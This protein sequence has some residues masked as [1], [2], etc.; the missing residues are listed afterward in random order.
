MTK[1]FEQTHSF[2]E[3][4]HG[5]ALAAGQDDAVELG[6]I[7][8][9]PHQTCP[10]AASFESALRAASAAGSPSER[11]QWLTEAAHGY[12]G[13]LLPGYFDAWVFPERERLAELQVRKRI[14][15]D[16]ED[17]AQKQQR[18]YFLRRQMDAMRR[19]FFDDR[20]RMLV[21]PPPRPMPDGPEE[22]STKLLSNDRGHRVPDLPRCL[23]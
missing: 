10:R 7:I 9:R 22:R 2:H 23:D 3:H 5:R 8:D 19:D 1:W 20:G 6:Q 18:E 11:E 17:G 12:R 14:H 16:V 21:P 13:E 15:D 4:R